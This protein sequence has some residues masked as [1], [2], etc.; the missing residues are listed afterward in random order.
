VG[1][2][3]ICPHLHDALVRAEQVHREKQAVASAE[4]VS[5]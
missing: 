2:Q 3:N 4:K 5:A 1:D